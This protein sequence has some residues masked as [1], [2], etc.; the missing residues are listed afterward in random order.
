MY[1][2]APRLDPPMGNLD[3]QIGGGDYRPDSIKKQGLGFTNNSPVTTY[4][5][6]PRM[7]W[8]PPQRTNWPLPPKE[9][10]RGNGREWAVRGK[11]QKKNV[12]WQISGTHLNKECLN[13]T[14]NLLKICRTEALR[15]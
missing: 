2:V 14:S 7:N 5:L 3:A 1:L 11:I 13:L 10:K 15:D 8:L 12:G 9:K 6:L 4:L